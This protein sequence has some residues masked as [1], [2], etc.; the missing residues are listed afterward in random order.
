VLE[1]TQLFDIGLSDDLRRAERGRRVLFL[2]LLKHLLLLLDAFRC[3]HAVSRNGLHHSDIAL[4]LQTLWDFGLS[5]YVL[6]ADSMKL[7]W[8]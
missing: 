1:Q 8:R 5:P 2:D 4:H 3:F 7:T 6:R